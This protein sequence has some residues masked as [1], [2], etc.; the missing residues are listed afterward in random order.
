M[1]FG[2]QDVNV[3]MLESVM[4]DAAAII[5]SLPPTNVKLTED[6]AAAWY[7]LAYKIKTVNP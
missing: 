4:E 5:I 6:V 2:W 7:A 3:D 1:V